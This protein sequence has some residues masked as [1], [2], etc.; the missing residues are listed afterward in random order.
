M[1]QRMHAAVSVAS[2][3]AG[4]LI[5]NRDQDFL[6]DFEFIAPQIVGGLQ[7]LSRSLIFSGDFIK[8]VPLSYGIFT[9]E[10][11]CRNLRRCALDRL[12]I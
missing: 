4:R 11:Q 1:P 7:V 9:G 3:W 8:G 5:R 2:D 12:R 10:I 6:P